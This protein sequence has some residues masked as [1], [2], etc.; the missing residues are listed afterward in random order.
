[1]ARVFASLGRSVARHPFRAVVVWLVLAVGAYL[2]AMVGVGNDTLFERVSSG[3]PQVQGTE[4]QRANAALSEGPASGE[5]VTLIVQGVEPGTKGIR[6][7]LAPAHRDLAAIDGVTS[8]VDPYLVPDGV[9]SPAAKPLLAQDGDGFLVVV[10]LSPDL[11]ADAEKTAQQAVAD[12]M[13]EIPAD[14]TSVA[15]DATALVGSNDLVV[16]AITDQLETDL[17]TGEAV[18]LPIAL[19]VMVLVFGG[20]LAA[21]MPIIGAFASIG[22]GLGTL[23]LLT[24][25]MDVDATVINVVTV[26]GIGLSIDY[27]LLMVSRFREELARHVDTGTGATPVRRR[28]RDGGVEKAVVT[29]VSTAGRTVAFSGVT[30]AVSVAALSVFAPSIM[31][32][33]GI[34][35]LCVILIAVA[36][37]LTLVPA[38]L[39]LAGTRLLRPGIVG[40]IPVLRTILRHTSDV[41]SDEGTFSRIARWVQRRPVVVM[42]GCLVVLGV[43]AAPAANLQ[44]RSSGIEM[45]PASSESRQFVDVLAE[46]YP[47]SRSPEVVTVVH[48]TSAQATA[49]AGAAKDVTGVRS[50]DAP[51]AIADGSWS[52]GIR[53]DDADA[54][55]QAVV[56]VVHDVRDLRATPGA[57]ST[58]GT[59]E[60]TGQAAQQIDFTKALTDRLWLALLIV[61]VATLVLLFLMTGSVVLPVKALIT[62]AIS[63]MASVGVLVWVFQEGHLSG[64]L[65][66]DSVGG[67]EPYIIALVLAFAFGLAMDY[68]VFLVSRIKEL[69]DQGRPT[70]EAVRVG[71]Q[72]SGRIITSA[73]LII[74]VVFAGFAAGKLLVI[75]EVGVA[76]AVAVALD[77]TLV[78]M[79]LVPATMTLLDR[80][81]WWAPKPLARL[82]QRIGI[83][84]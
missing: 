55:S 58:F 20:L 21:A 10:E 76:L 64:L 12:R 27:G 11:G 8:V 15:P 63:L 24:Y 44:L 19:V 60:V 45:L 47:A 40:R 26:L 67:I 2:V 22:V 78:R 41:T 52:V 28:R 13:R 23:Y 46:Q 5:S 37:A 77:A 36:S 83:T 53:T 35:G 72:R 84:H 1:M 3:D 68:E 17:R 16:S 61:V 54:G 74:I 4:S 50:V 14:L 69:H 57:A 39:R 59:F 32:A 75:K 66:F 65:G 42:L 82:A 18:A 38:L 31:R 71:L 62:N 70:S 48:G 79:L 6:E 73:A 9:G 81:N 80:W 43:L 30:V 34:A 56:G 51:V 29:T 7:A 33:I 49:F 25:L